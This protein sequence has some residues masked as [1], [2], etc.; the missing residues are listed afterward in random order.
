MLCFAV[1]TGCVF[2]SSGE[3]EFSVRQAMKSKKDLS[4]RKKNRSITLRINEL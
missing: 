1:V 4:R 3:R 2:S